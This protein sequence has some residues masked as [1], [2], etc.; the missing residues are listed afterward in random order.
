M[1]GFALRLVLKQRQKRTIGNGLLF[2]TLNVVHA[3]WTWLASKIDTSTNA[4]MD[5]H[6][7]SLSSIDLRPVTACILNWLTVVWADKCEALKFK[8]FNWR[9]HKTTTRSCGKTIYY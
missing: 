8:V 1:N 9:A 5:K 3:K 2:V 4:G 7:N 6:A